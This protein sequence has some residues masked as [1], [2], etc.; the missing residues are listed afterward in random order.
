MVEGVTVITVSAP[1][2]LLMSVYIFLEGLGTAEAS[3]VCGVFK[4]HSSP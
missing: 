1:H 2:I 4:L 3:E